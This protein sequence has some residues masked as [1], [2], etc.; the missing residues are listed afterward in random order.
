[1]SDNEPKRERGYLIKVLLAI[2]WPMLS[3]FIAGG[4]IGLGLRLISEYNPA[5]REALTSGSP[6][7]LLTLN[8]L[9][10]IVALAVVSLP[11]YRYFFG[12]NHSKKEV[13]GVHRRIKA[14]DAGLVLIAFGTY[15]IASAAIMGLVSSFLPF[16]DLDQPQELGLADPETASQL[17]LI[18]L[19]LVVAAPIAEELIF[20]GFM[21]KALRE[22]LSFW[23]TAILV[24]IAFGVAHGQLN[25]GID[26]FVLSIF[27][28]A[29][30]EYTG[31]IWASMLLHALKNFLAFSV[32]FLFPDL[33]DSLMQNAPAILSTLLH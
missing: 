3:V 1:M 28:C 6:A 10:Y 19:M 2:I 15:F 32:L 16:I 25:V 33:L 12:K 9:I 20:R 7:V 18:F 24:S 11:L 31:T 27:L 23:P 13:Y 5:V 8:A 21:F 22:R 29:L 4:L 17:V 14:G 26:T 30:R